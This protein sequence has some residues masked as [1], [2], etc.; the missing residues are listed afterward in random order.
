MQEGD[1]YKID[2]EDERSAHYWVIASQPKL[3]GTFVAIS[4]TDVLN[5]AHFRDVWVKGTPIT[6]GFSLSKSSVLAFPYAQRWTE[7][8]VRA[9]PHI[10][11]GTCFPEVL[12]RVRSNLLWYEDFLKP[13]VRKECA[14]YRVDWIR[15]CGPPPERK[16]KA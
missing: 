3:D 16:A 13:A 11:C 8:D 2:L 15:P 9:R 10:L 4:F 7:A 12:Q 1:V 6:P 14:F 5:V